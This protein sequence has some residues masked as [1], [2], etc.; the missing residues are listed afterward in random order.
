VAALVA[1][2]EARIASFAADRERIFVQANTS[3]RQRLRD[4]SAEHLRH[5]PGALI[6][7]TFCAT[8][9]TASFMAY[10]FHEL[11]PYV[12][13]GNPLTLGIIEFFAIPGALIGAVL[14]PL[15]LDGFVWQYGSAPGATV[16]LKAFAP[17]ALIFLSL[18]VLSAV[19]WRTALSRVT[20]IPLAI[21]GLWGAADYDIAIA[22]TGDSAAVRTADGQL[23][24]LGARP[25]AFLSEQWL[26]ADADP[27]AP[28]AA[29]SGAQCDA[30]GCAAQLLDGRLVALLRTREALVEDCGRA[31]LVIAPFP[32][33]SGCGAATIIDRRHL[34]TT[35]AVTLKILGEQF[36]MR[37]ARAIGE[38]RPWSRAPADIRSARLGS[39]TGK[40]S[41]RI[42]KMLPARSI[43]WIDAIAPGRFAKNIIRNRASCRAFR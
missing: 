6:F 14:Y 22:A 40:E 42:L 17:Y 13:I 39:G 15:G 10:D 29:Q 33:P 27:R 2:Y 7:A 32:V 28:K 24:V 37:S 16:H 5:G 18:A 11:S 30:S 8:A 38:N 20:A 4:F 21:I 23:A 36:E 35:G 3:L 41:T 12:L 31:A 43:V 9:A 1:V 25:S 26:R 19:I 34:D